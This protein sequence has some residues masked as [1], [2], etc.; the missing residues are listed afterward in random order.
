MNNSSLDFIK[1][2]LDKQMS[3][4]VG[5]VFAYNGNQDL[6]KDRDLFIVLSIAEVTPYSNNTRYVSTSEGLTEVQ[7]SN[8]AEDIVI[9][10]MSQSTQARDRAH[11]AF[12]ALRSTF[13]QYVQEKNKFHI[14]TINPVRD[15]SFLEGSANL[16]RFDIEVRVIKAYQITNLIDYY[17][18]FPNTSEFEADLYINE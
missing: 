1:Q 7:T 14:S 16:Y 17:D 4:P 9:S 2:I 11:E 10:L 3:M 13:A 15:M 12:M 5:R 6:P 8:T 18:K